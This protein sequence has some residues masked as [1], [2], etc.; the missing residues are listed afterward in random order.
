MRLIDEKGKLFGKV[1]VIDFLVI[2]FFVTVLPLFF[3]GY[4]LFTKPELKSTVNSQHPLVETEI[5]CFFSRV[6]PE[7]IKQISIGDKD[8]GPGS[9]LIAEVIKLGKPRPHRYEFDLG[10]GESIVM[11]DKIFKDLPAKLKISGY[12]RAD[13]LYYKDI[14][15]KIDSSFEFQAKD[16]SANAVIASEFHETEIEFYGKFVAVEPELVDLI[17]LG[18]QEIIGKDS[19][20]G[21]IT[22][23]GEVQPYQFLLDI[24][25]GRRVL[26]KDE[27]LKEVPARLKIQMEAKNN[28]IYYK[29][30]KIIFNSPFKFSTDGYAVKFLPEKAEEEM[31]KQIEQVGISKK[32]VLNMV[33]KDLEMDTLK[34]ISV[35]DREIGENGEVLAE[36]LELGEIETS[37][38]DI[39][40]GPR[41]FILVEDASKKQISVKMSLSCDMRKTGILF[42]KDKKLTKN[43]LSEFNMGDYKVAG[44]VAKSYR[45]FHSLSEE[46][47]VSLRAKFERVIPEISKILSKG[48]IEKNP[49]GRTVGRIIGVLSSKLS[50]KISLQDGEFITTTHPFYR[51]IEVAMEFL[52]LDEDGILYFKNFPVGMN[53]S[54]TFTTDLYSLSGVIIGLEE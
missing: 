18:D 25:S 19:V 32:L 7:I 34:L 23:L 13:A 37:K 6:N 33:L 4:R 43:S 29:N 20:I 36:I 28:A 44:M 21:V 22:W 11:E 2:I 31:S 39:E 16:Y 12:A 1:N 46:R 35:G 49:V 40:L 30:T 50:S 53:N 24:G 42:Y 15:L 48:D 45:G 10:D 17:S 52:C 41:N 5:N 54:I 27:M 51:D 9:E 26:K 38:Y 47:W 8:I 14:P 3:F